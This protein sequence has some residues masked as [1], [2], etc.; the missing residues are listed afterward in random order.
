MNLI[1]L[2]AG[3][4]GK[5]VEDIA[6]DL[7]KYKEITFL[8]DN[9]KSSDVIGK[10]DD[11]H[12]FINKD[13]EFFVAFGNNENRIKWINILKT[14]HCCLATL[15]SLNAYVSKKASIGIGSIVLPK[16][17]VNTNAVIGEGCIL[18]I[19]SLIDHDVEIKNGVHICLGAIV[20]ANN[21]VPP[22]LKLEAG[23]IIERNMME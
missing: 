19:G 1:I 7:N 9:N 22:F 2:G 11:F 21:I 6:T 4:F 14:N 13:T 5:V 3:G 23:Q 12:K 8:D 15:I 20:K 10:L 16:C 18:N 17:V